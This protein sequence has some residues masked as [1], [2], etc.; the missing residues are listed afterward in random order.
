MTS[1]ERLADSQGDQSHDIHQLPGLFL[2][3]D[4][5]PTSFFLQ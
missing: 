4:I 3:G 2:R 5:V 1:G